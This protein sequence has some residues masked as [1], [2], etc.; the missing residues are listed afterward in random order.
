M[1]CW[2]ECSVCIINTISK[3]MFILLVQ[4]VVD[5]LYL[6][7]LFVH[8]ST[9]KQR[10]KVHHLFKVRVKHTQT[11]CVH[12][13][14]SWKWTLLVRWHH[15][16]LSSGT[17]YM[18]SAHSNVKL[19]FCLISTADFTLYT[20]HVCRVRCHIVHLSS[21]EALPVIRQAKT[22]GAPLTVETTHHYLCLA[23]DTIPSGAT[24]YK[25]CPPIR[26]KNNQVTTNQKLLS[27]H[28]FPIKNEQYFSL[29]I[30]N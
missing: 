13:L 26:N 15:C 10:N 11:S 30:R 1:S 7:A 23:A 4:V 9:L 24:Q 20:C 16:A 8:S 28:C 29:Q 5:V 21:A 12:V 2:Y 6:V 17:V 25:C 19:Y 22:G 27:Q 3:L 18:F 14:M